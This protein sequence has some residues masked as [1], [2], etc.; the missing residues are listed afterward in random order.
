[1]KSTV[2]FV[3]C[4]EDGREELVHEVMSFD[5]A[6]QRIEHFGLTLAEAKS[7]LKT[8]QQLTAQCSMNLGST[9]GLVR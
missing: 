3:V 9:R 6:S 4:S 2:Q 8:L 7:I 1:M 5:K